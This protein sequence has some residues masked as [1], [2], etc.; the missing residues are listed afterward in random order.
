MVSA[1]MDAQSTASASECAASAATYC[2]TVMKEKR[3]PA[4]NS[5]RAFFDS[6]RR[7]RRGGATVCDGAAGMATLDSG[8]MGCMSAALHITVSVSRPTL[9]DDGNARDPTRGKK[10]FSLDQ[11]PPE[12]DFL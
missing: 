8:C 12:N 7:R 6:R 1:S 4:S 10:N 9:S 11:K 5:T 2:V 3:M